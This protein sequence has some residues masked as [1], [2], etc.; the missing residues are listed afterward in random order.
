MGNNDYCASKIVLN[1]PKSH[2]DYVYE[3]KGANIGSNNKMKSIY[4]SVIT[5]IDQ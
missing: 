5:S 3:L 2:D 4:I 1:A